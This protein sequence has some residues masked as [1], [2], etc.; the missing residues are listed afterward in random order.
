[1]MDIADYLLRNSEEIVTPSL[2]IYPEVVD[3]NIQ[4]AIRVMRGNPDRW[5]PHFKT[6]KSGWVARRLRHFGVNQVKV[7][8]TL[9]LAVVCEAGIADVL[10]AYP[11]VGANARRVDEIA[12]QFPETRIS[13]L[14]ETEAQLTLWSGSRIG[15]F[16]DINPGMDRTGVRQERAQIILDLARA[17]G[18]AFRGVHYYD[19]QV[20]SPD[21]RDREIKAH[22]G[23]KR[24]MEIIGY[25]EAQGTPAREVVTSGTPVFPF[26]I[27]FEGFQ[28]GRFV[29]RV[30]PG[31]ILF[32]DLGSLSQLPPSLGFRAAALVLAT[33]VSHP[34]PLYATCDAGH[35]SV[36]ADAGV[37]TCAVVGRPDLEPLKPSEE[38]LPLRA[39]NL[40]AVPAIGEQLYLLP[41]HVC[42]TVNNFD[43][44]LLV[45]R[46][47]IQ[48][49]Q[50]IDARGHENP[51]V[52][53][54]AIP[55]LT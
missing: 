2:L 35:K 37:P 30:S 24:L 10:I 31:T 25:L 36:S 5:R 23:Y 21:L 1:M 4:A 14:V 42:P 45:V 3:S 50:A 20:T 22:E 52:S 29:H 27:S 38:H 26:A 16:V 9:E 39:A 53:Y 7:S 18:P 46:G 6:V 54:P 17:A 47:E 28:S 43:E 11:L 12:A 41:R 13:V 8:T 40:E 48:S 49:A 19:G 34:G 15:V 32:N 33:V 51:A 55:A 44:A